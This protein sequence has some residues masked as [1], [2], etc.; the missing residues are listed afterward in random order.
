[1]WEMPGRMVE[2]EKMYECNL[3]LVVLT[4]KLTGNSRHTAFLS[5][6]GPL[7]PS[8]AFRPDW[9]LRQELSLF[10]LGAYVSPMHLV[11]LPPLV[12]GST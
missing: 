12:E 1:M 6:L 7:K 8:G 11:A 2:P 5:T 3:W 10:R 9:H 4:D